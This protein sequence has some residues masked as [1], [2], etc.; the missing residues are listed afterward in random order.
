MN[1]RTSKQ[2]FS[3][4]GMILFIFLLVG[5]G[6]QIGGVLLSNHIFGGADKAPEYMFWIIT[7]VPLYCVAF[8]LTCFLMKRVP[9]ED[10]KETTSIGVGKWFYFLAIAFFAMVVGSIIGSIVGAVFKIFDI[11]TGIA[12]ESLTSSNSSIGAVVLALLAPIVE[13]LIFRKFLIDRMHMFGGHVA[14]MTSALMFGLF[15]GNFSQFFYAWF[16]GIVFGY[17]YYKTG[18][19]L[20]TIFMHMFINFL[21]GVIAPR[22]LAGVDLTETDPMVM[23]SSPAFMGLMGYVAFMYVMAIVGAVFFFT[24]K[25]KISYAEES[26]QIPKEEEKKVWCNVGMILF[27]LGCIAFFI[28]SLGI[29]YQG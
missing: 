5:S 11:N 16:L 22:L 2:T 10:L 6:L 27:T 23:V 28:Y 13:E 12:V 7:F 29:G 25:K 26:L 3:A 15:H 20:Y 4:L 17:V 19:V 21:G 8:P 14:V 18:N 1:E 24:G 9:R